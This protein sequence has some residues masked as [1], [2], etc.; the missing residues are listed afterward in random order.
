MCHT[1]V[2]IADN[3]S[4]EL[5]AILMM[6]VVVVWPIVTRLLRARVLNYGC[7]GRWLEELMEG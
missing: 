1:E 7:L 6:V 5:L 2:D 3:I 4:E